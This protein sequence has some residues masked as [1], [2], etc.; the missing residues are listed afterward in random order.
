MSVKPNDARDRDAD[1]GEPVYTYLINQREEI[2][3]VSDSWIEFA[4]ENNARELVD[5]VGRSL[6]E[7]IGHKEVSD[8]YRHLVEK[9]RRT[10]GALLV[11]F[12]CD[13]PTIRRF[14][15]LLIERN[16]EDIKFEGRTVRTEPRDSVSLFDPLIERAG[17]KL[18]ACSVC[19]NLHLDGSWVDLEIALRTRKLFYRNS[20]PNL[21]YSICPRCK[22]KPVFS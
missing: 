19:Q 7:F 4:L 14:M 12:R 11:P 20:S 5:I 10:G 8:F 16:G 6:Y 13:G 15:E 18:E 2:V 22:E 17:D 3:S 9:V 1:T 21:D